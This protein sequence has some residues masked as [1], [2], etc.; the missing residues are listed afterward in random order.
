MLPTLPAACDVSTIVVTDPGTDPDD[1]MAMI[2]MRALIEDGLMACSAVIANTYPAIERARLSRRTLD[3]LGLQTIEVGCGSDGGK[4]SAYASAG[5]EFKRGVDLIQQ[6]YVAA[7]PK[8]VQLVL[9]SKLTD[10]AVFIHLF[11]RLFV[12][13]TLRVVIMGGV[14]EFDGKYLEPDGAANNA[15]DS[16]A[17]AAVYRKCQDLN[18]QLVVVTRHLAYACRMPKT[19]F[20]S[21]AETGHPLGLHMQSTQRESVQK[22]WRQACEAS[23]DADPTTVGQIKR[24]KTWFCKQFCD[25]AGMDR[26]PES[27]VW[28]IFTGFNMYDPLALMAAIP[29]LRCKFFESETVRVKTTDHLVIGIRAEK[30]GIDAGKVAPAREFLMKSFQR[31]LLLDLSKAPGAASE[32]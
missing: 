30:P 5:A 32:V 23:K 29:E 10:A 26:S 7:A 6:A 16:E 8:S 28:D 17:A 3:A 21:L 11:E 12:R 18:I 1:E 2:L 14:K 15:S 19:L 22:F 20:D 13:K 24:D 9:I 4:D 27:D 25:G 31:G